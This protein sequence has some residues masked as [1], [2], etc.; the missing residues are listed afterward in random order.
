MAKNITKFLILVVVILIW[1]PTGIGDF[2]WLPMIIAKIGMTMYVII[3]IG[4]VVYLYRTIEG[5]TIKSKIDN[6]RRELKRW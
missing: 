2:I 3:S 1:L 6:I 5:K 4:M